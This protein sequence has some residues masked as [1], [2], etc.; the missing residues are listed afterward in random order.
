MP[1]TE[2]DRK[3]RRRQRRQKRMRSLKKEWAVATDAKTKKKLMEKVHRYQ[4]WWE[5]PEE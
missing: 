2:K 3:R 4:P 5:G 1:L